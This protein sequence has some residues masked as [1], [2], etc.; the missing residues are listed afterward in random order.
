MKNYKL[1]IDA[2]CPVC[3][4]IGSEFERNGVVEKNTCMPYQE[5][6][7]S[8]KNYVDSW[9]S[10]NEVALIN[11]NT[12]EVFYG[13]DAFKTIVLYHFP[14]FRPIFEF[15][16]FLWLFNQIYLLIAFNRR[17]IF[18][19]NTK[20]IDEKYKPSLNL[21]YR[22]FYIFLANIVFACLMY[23]VFN[24]FYTIK[25]I[26]LFIIITGAF[27]YQYFIAKML[28]QNNIWEYL[29]NLA[30][31]VFFG[32]LLLIP[33]IIIEK[34]SELPKWA[35]GLNIIFSVIIALILHNH[36]CE[37]LEIT[38]KTTWFLFLYIFIIISIV[39]I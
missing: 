28:K 14:F 1:L 39:F 18:F 20:P 4:L 30:T 21:K 17:V 36:R 3:S 13:I 6:D 5:I 11:L 10:K 15:K 2:D 33:L 23:V 31:I 27:A 37:I 35:Y 19:S 8:L 16:P 25:F 29:G 38:K 32:S 26:A 12:Y 22:I 24:Q 9:R 34:I 7:I